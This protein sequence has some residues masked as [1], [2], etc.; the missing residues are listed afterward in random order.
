MEKILISAC[1][2]GDNVRYDGGNNLKQ[3]LLGLLDYYE[4]VPFCPEHEGGLPIPRKPSEVRGDTVRNSE[5]DDVTNAFELGASKAV[6][7]CSLLGITLAIMKERSPSCG[8]HQIHNGSFDGTLIP[9][10]GITVRRLKRAG[11]R[12]MNED[13]ALEFLR[14][15]QESEERGK[16]IKAASIARQEE[17]KLLAS[18][19]ETPANER[20]ERPY[21]RKPRYHD[22]EGRPS[23]RRPYDKEGKKP[24]SKD[25]SRSSYKGERKPYSKDGRKPFSKDGRKP[26][27]K[28]GRKPYSKD[29][30]K[31]F[32]NKGKGAPRGKRPY[33]K[34]DS[35]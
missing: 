21:Q 9:G 14:K 25:G 3:E 34:K 35:E 20:E 33:K 31:P 16:V 7:L 30:R 27:S 29:G 23:Y 24:Y 6:S 5:G 15:R 4:L 12:V 11:V 13:E 2:I 10:E 28:D 22:G 26:Y 18:K 17:E 8:S 19:E 32:G 1:L